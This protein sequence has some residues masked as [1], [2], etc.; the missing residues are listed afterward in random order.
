MLKTAQ[1]L[2]EQARKIRLNFWLINVCSLCG[3][4]CG[5]V[6]DGDNVYYDSGCDCGFGHEPLQPRSWE[7]LAEQYNRNQPENNPKISKEYLDKTE[8]IWKFN[9]NKT[10]SHEKHIERH[11]ELHQKLDELVADYI[12]CT[13]KTLS[14]S[15]IMDLIKW[16]SEQC[17]KPNEDKK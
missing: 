14:N 8:A 17:V 6:I 10:M 3:Y 1:E 11:K 15:S 16:S 4:H 2:K 5:Y 7:N 12:T 9:E 13:E